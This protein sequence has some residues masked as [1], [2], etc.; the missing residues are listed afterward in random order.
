MKPPALFALALLAFSSPVVAQE[1]PLKDLVG[2]NNQIHDA[3]YGV[4]FTLPA[5]WEV[6]GAQRWGQDNQENTIFLSAVWPSE[7]RPSV[8][9]A[10]IREVLAP[11]QAEDYFRRTAVTKAESRV[12]GGMR[13]YVNVPASFVMK[14]INGRESLSYH[15]T[16]SRGTVKMVEYFTRIAGAKVMVMLFAQIPL[17]EFATLQPELD[18]MM[19]TVKVP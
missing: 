14:Q 2:P 10:P 16:F 12:K 18:R 1:I 13:D 9:Y 7:S 17:E 11:G 8:Y 4:S 3:L 5:G 15:A 6:R 19:A